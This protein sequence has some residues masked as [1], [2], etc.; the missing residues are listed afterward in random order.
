M[1]KKPSS[2]SGLTLPTCSRNNQ[3]VRK[4]KIDKAQGKIILCKMINWKK[5]I[6]K[7]QGKKNPS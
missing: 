5:K 6:I 3:T 1:S 7:N 4:V 2:K